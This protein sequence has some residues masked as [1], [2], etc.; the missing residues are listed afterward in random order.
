MIAVS[1]SGKSFRGLAAYLATGR[2]RESPERMAWSTSRN[3][4]TNEPELAA[5]F[6]RATATRSDRIEKPVYHVVLSFDPHDR[7]D[8][9]A[10]ERVADRILDRLGLA[11]HQA[12]IVA[13]GDRKHPHVH[14]FVNRVH[15]ETGRAWE[16]WKDQPIIQQVLREEETALGLRPVASSLSPTKERAE[17][18]QLRLEVGEETQESARPSRQRGGAES[19][20]KLDELKRDLGA[21]ERIEELTR[22]VSAAKGEADAARARAAQLDTMFDRTRAADESFARA[23]RAVYREPEEARAG[24]SA[25]AAEK[26]QTHAVA[27]LREQPERFGALVTTERRRVL[28]MVRTEDVGPARAAATEAAR[29]GEHALAAS[30]AFV[31]AATENRVRRLEEAFARELRALY[32]R[33]EVARRQF[34]ALAQQH[35]AERASAIVAERP[36]DLGELRLV[37]QREPDR[38]GVLAASTAAAGLEAARARADW[39]TEKAVTRT[40]GIDIAAASAERQAGTADARMTADRERAT[41]TELKRLPRESEL[42]QRIATAVFYLLPHEIRMMKTTLTA[43][44]IALAMKLRSTARDVLLGREGEARG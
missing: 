33:P 20:R 17:A 43:P 13:H 5:T 40:S 44:H 12:V 34:E 16:R 28:G 36:R 24:F 15:P 19:A 22:E 37:A 18:S 7:V 32:E 39:N 42:R 8:R 14:I 6:M 4:P 21:H 41:R 27:A 1:S 9:A 10:M 23:L 31:V 30:C 38:L 29:L 3:L 26:G 2:D 35:G 11:E 25:L